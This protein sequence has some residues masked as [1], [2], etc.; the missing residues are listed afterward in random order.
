MMHK[1]IPV[2][3]T[4]LHQTA[5]QAIGDFFTK[6]PQIDTVLV[7]NSCARGVAVPE[8]D[9]DFAILAK[10][11]TTK[12]ALKTIEIKWKKY[13]EQDALLN[14]FTQSHPFAKI[15]LDV[16]QGEYQPA[17][18]DDGGGPDYFEVEIGNHVRYSCVMGNTGDYFKELRK[19]WLPY[20]DELLRLERLKM[21]KQ[22]CLFDLEHIP[23][24]VKR[25]LYFQAFD[26][27]YKA[28][29]EFLQAV[30]IQNK[31]Y[32]IAYN[33]WIKEQMEQWL[34]LPDLYPRLA[35]VLSVSNIES[36]E[37]NLKAGILESLLFEFVP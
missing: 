36:D 14:K 31:L 23:F 32:P 5:A 11:K 24:F 2:F 8:S 10:P 6:I 9:L 1:T 16:I 13:A 7:V 15:H 29:Q 20:Y 35:P 17:I 25:K 34:C 22:A 28:F 21:V 33:K 30:F 19:T 26:R 12:A 37:L 4:A 18:W 3:P 27:L